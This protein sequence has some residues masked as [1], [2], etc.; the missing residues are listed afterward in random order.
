MTGRSKFYVRLYRNQPA[1]HGSLGISQSLWPPVEIAQHDQKVAT[2]LR[3]LGNQG[4]TWV[5]LYPI[6]EIISAD[7]GGESKIRENGW[8]SKKALTR[9]RG[10]V[11]NPAAIGDDA[12]H[13]VSSKTPPRKPMTQLEAESFIK[14]ILSN[15]LRSKEDNQ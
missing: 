9:F 15:W 4:S 6:L 7:L 12:R 5:N 3:L 8:A 10:S 13:G 11:N 14:S 1:S 2:A